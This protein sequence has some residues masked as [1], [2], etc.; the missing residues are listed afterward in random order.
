MFG[1]LAHLKD[2]RENKYALQLS[3]YRKMLESDAYGLKVDGCMLARLGADGGPNVQVL[4]TPYFDQEAGALL[5]G[6]LTLSEPELEGEN[7]RD[8]RITFDEASHQYRVKTSDG[9]W[10]VVPKSVTGLVSLYA[11][12]FVPDAVIARMKKSRGWGPGHKYWGM[13]DAEIKAAWKATA[14]LGTSVHTKIDS[15]YK[16]PVPG[17]KATDVHDGFQTFHMWATDQGLDPVRSEWPVH[18]GL[19]AGTVD[20]VYKKPNGAHFIV[21]WKVTDTPFA[22]SNFGVPLR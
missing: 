8:Q 12:P 18:C 4:E 9:T 10:K 15:F 6:A 17:T 16:Q 21:D 2:T 11:P 3:L 7:D 1:P 22:G 19:V 20:M 14:V 5:G 13:T